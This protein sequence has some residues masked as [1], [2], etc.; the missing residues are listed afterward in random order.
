MDNGFY[1]ADP[2]PGNLMRT[3]DGKLAYLGEAVIFNCS[4]S[5]CY[6]GPHTLMLIDIV[7]RLL[8]RFHGNTT[9]ARIVAQE[10][11]VV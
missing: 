8:W 7:C 4:Y 11:N 3:Y 9:Q 10:N 2:H 1:H 6:K 5:A